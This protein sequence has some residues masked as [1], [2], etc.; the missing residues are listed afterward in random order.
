MTKSKSFYATS[1][2]NAVH[3]LSVKIEVRLRC[4]LVPLLQRTSHIST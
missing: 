4:A 1:T 2:Y 3:V